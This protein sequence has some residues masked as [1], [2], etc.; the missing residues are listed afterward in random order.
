MVRAARKNQ[1]SEININLM[2][3]EELGGTLGDI[4]RWV[5]NV[6][7]YLIIITEIIA[8]ATFGLSLKLTIDKNNLNKR[9]TVAQDTIGSKALF[10]KEFRGVQ[11]KIFE[12]KDLRAKHLNNHL[13]LE[14]F[15]KLLPE[16]LTINSLSIDDVEL[17]FSGNFAGAAQLQ[18]LINSFNRSEATDKKF[19]GL[20]I[21]ELNSPSAKDPE[22]SFDAKVII[23]RAAF[24]V[25]ETKPSNSEN[26]N[27]QENTR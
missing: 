13:V 12:I 8:L 24:K 11:N 20:E 22:F 21:S 1:P 10:E 17:A 2:P 4:V 5:L 3:K 16:G 7:R 9:V 19:I 6:G 23:N 15:N 26:N 25:V 27:L 18:T 14:D